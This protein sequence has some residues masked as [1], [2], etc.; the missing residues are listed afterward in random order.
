MLLYPVARIMESK[1]RS[2]P[3][4]NFAP[5]FVIS[6]TPSTTCATAG[7]V[8]FRERERECTSNSTIVFVWSKVYLYF[9]GFDER[10]SAD[11]EDGGLSG[12]VLEL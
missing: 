7:V 11:V 4:M 12:G 5:F 2:W 3:S 1:S 8:V 9:A 6:F 10:E